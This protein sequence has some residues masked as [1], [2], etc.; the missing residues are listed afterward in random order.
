MLN[1][2]VALNTSNLETSVPNNDLLQSDRL[3]HYIVEQRK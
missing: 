2:K 1:G 3:F